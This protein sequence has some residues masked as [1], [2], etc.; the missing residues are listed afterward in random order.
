MTRKPLLSVIMSIYNQKAFVG[1]SIESILNQT[2]CDFEFIIINDRCTDGTSAI[3]KEYAKNDARI[4]LFYN[5]KR[6]GLTI[7]LNRGLQHAQGIFVARQ[8]GDDIS[9]PRRFEKQVNYLRKHPSIAIVG[10]DYVRIYEDLKK[11]A[12]FQQPCSDKEIKTFLAERITPLAAVM[13]RRNIVEVI[14]GYNEKVRFAQDYEFYCRVSATYKCA[15]ISEPLSR[16]R[17]HNK[18]ISVQKK[19]EQ[20]AYVDWVASGAI[21]HKAFATYFKRWRLYNRQFD[22][23]RKKFQKK[24]YDE[25]VKLFSKTLYR[26]QDMPLDVQYSV[27]SAAKTT[28]QIHLAEKIFDAIIANPCSSAAFRGGSLFH[29]GEIERSRGAHKKALRYFKQCLKCI[30]T[31]RKAKD[32]CVHMG[33]R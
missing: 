22:I 23:L 25:V 20:R 18:N 24:K 4:R 32:H 15:N 16:R 19:S 31:H 14:G 30:P 2:F 11:E 21:K 9:H 12:Y 17:F 28:M 26:C 10:S 27:A 7:S 13:F 3:L 8:D 1:D 6:V 29:L 5:Q 33:K